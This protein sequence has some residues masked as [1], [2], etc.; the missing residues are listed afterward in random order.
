MR[1]DKILKNV[2]W[3][4]FLVDDKNILVAKILLMNLF[5]SDTG[6]QQD[7]DFCEQESLQ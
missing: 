1:A 6:S 2:W 4:V 5:K 3:M 7:D